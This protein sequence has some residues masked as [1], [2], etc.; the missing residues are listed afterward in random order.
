MNPFEQLLKDLGIAMNLDLK[1]D[2]HGSCLLDF[3][4]GINIQIDMA[5]DGERILIGSQVVQL[6]PG[7]FREIVF[8]EALKHNSVNKI[9]VGIFAYSSKNDTLILFQYLYFKNINGQELFNYLQEFAT[10]ITLWREGLNRGQV[11]QIEESAASGIFGL[12]H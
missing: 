7:N 11:P 4:N 2:A 5:E 1:P 3:F 12:K 8:K 6:N 9:L 10:L